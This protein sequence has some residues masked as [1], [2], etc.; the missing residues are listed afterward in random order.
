[1]TSTP[2]QRRHV[3]AGA[4]GL[5]A[6]AVVSACGGGSTGTTDAASTHDSAQPTATTAEPPAV[7][8]PPVR[9]PFTGATPDIPAGPHGVPA[10]YFHYPANPPTFVTDP[11]GNG[12]EVSILTQGTVPQ[13]EDKNKAWQEM[14]R[15]L[16]VDLKIQTVASPDYA[17]KFRLLTAGGDLPD[18]LLIDQGIPQL[19]DVLAKEFADLTDYLSGD[20][21]N[22][23]PGLASIPTATWQIPTI[24]GRIWG[25]AQA[26]IPAG[27]ILS[28]RQD[29]LDKYG[30]T[31]D[32][33]SGQDF[34]DL[35][36]ELSDPKHH[37]WAMGQVPT[38]YALPGV[39]E[40]MEAPN[41]WR[42][43]GGKFIHVN[44][45]PQM[46]EALDVVRTMWDK[47]YLHP[48]SFASPDQLLTW[49][50]GGLTSLYFQNFA[51]W[52]DYSI[53][54]PTWTIGVIQLPKWGGGGMAAKALAPAGY[55]AFAG[56]KK[57]EPDRIKELL[58][59][60]NYFASP[61]GTQEYLTANFG[62]KDVDYKLQ[63]S[64]PVRIPHHPGGVPI[65]YLGS[66]AYDTLYIAGDADLV[67]AE[68]DY[69]T[70]VLPTGV[71]NAAQGLYSP[72]ALGAGAA[73]NEAVTDV[74]SDIIQG[75]KPVSSWDDALKTWLDKAGGQIAQEYEQAYASIH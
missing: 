4:V 51:G 66:Q 7:A 16:H 49:W 36:Q 25:V 33:K 27:M 65:S 63:G 50:S 9:A 70:A 69:L 55:G 59:V 44:Q 38:T 12:G 48:D 13:P 47:E 26:R 1:M 5:A 23:Y 6:S 10:G 42:Q 72:T 54:N 61:F 30:I 57:A 62:V 37:R 2:I 19:P 15:V 43:E 56:F 8:A 71:A 60:V 34:L 28:T 52:G 39:L 40:M 22:D 32:V 67:N 45:S 14:N 41:G 29:L 35:C 11:I 24:N 21:V 3:L 75:R 64:D 31:P 20:A 46:K 53:R 18:I 74:Q 17:A 58:R 68:H 73:A